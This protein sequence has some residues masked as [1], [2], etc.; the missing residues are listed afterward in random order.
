MYFSNKHIVPK[1]QD[2]K[3]ISVKI[4][5]LKMKNV[6]DVNNTKDPRSAIASWKY[7]FIIKYIDKTKTIHKKILGSLRKI[8]FKPKY[9]IRKES[10]KGYPGGETIS[11][12][13][14]KDR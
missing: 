13:R 9:L 7:C 5:C 1:T 8:R 12:S 3:G 2:K 6:G 11:R 14:S 4:F 10:K